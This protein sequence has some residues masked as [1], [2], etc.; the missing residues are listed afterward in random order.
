M[1]GESLSIKE[2]GYCETKCISIREVQKKRKNGVLY[3]N[4]GDD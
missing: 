1:Q 4:R 2:N 3:Q